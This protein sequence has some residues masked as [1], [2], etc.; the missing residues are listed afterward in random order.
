M[1][2]IFSGTEIVM[3]GIQIEK[4]GRDFYNALILQSQNPKAKELYKFLAGEEEKHILAFQSMLDKLEETQP[5]DSYPGEYISYMKTL[6]A[7]YVF[8]Q[9]DKGQALAKTAKS[10]KEAIEMGIRFEKDSILFYEAMKKSIPQTHQ[11]IVD[12]LILQEVSHLK[13]LSDLKNSLGS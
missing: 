12:Q 1:A 8:T 5:V 9:E 2:N 6:A 13:K 10:D 4:N 11:V 7:E 3:M